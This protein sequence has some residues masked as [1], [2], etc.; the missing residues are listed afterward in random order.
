MSSQVST[1]FEFELNSV[2]S[3]IGP[4]KTV[5]IDQ[6]EKLLRDLQSSGKG[7]SFA[8]RKLEAYIAGNIVDHRE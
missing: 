8:A 4:E 3:K 2:L 6:A 7:G 1:D 5:P